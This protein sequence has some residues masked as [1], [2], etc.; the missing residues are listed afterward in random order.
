LVRLGGVVVGGS[1]ALAVD[2]LAPGAGFEAAAGLDLVFFAAGGAGRRRERLADCWW[3]PFE[4]A[5]PVRGF[6]SFRGQRNFPGLWWS[7][8]SGAHVGFESWLERD[9]LMLLDFDR[10]V[11]AF[12][13]Q[14]FWIEWSSQGR[15]RRHAPDFFARRADGTGVVIDVRHDARIGPADAEAFAVTAAGCEAVGWRYQRV[16]QPPAV[17]TANV[18]WL[19]GYRHPRCWRPGLA[20]QLREVCRVP[21]GLRSGAEAVGEAVVVLPVLFHLLW[22]GTCARI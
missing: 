7:A 10:Q 12:A 8:T 18:R 17:L 6:P 21:R 13:A 2:G 1:S 4:R 20:E 19:S 5:V 16:G 9:H 3:E 15:T 11:L 22:R 14:P